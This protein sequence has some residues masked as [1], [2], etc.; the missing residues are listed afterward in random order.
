MMR[1]LAEVIDVY[2]ERARA[3]LMPR[4]FQLS[5]FLYRKQTV[6]KRPISVNRTVRA[7]IER[8]AKKDARPIETARASDEDLCFPERKSSPGSHGADSVA[9]QPIIVR[10]R[11]KMPGV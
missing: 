9:Y 7:D 11:Q 10:Q 6:S 8:I 5:T 1:S 2:A 3:N 4:R